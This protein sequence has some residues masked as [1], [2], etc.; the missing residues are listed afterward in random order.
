MV[1]AKT[2]FFKWYWTLLKETFGSAPSSVPTP[3]LRERVA[4]VTVAQE[5]A[6]P[7]IAAA[8]E[9][10]SR[11]SPEEV[12]PAFM[13]PSVARNL[14][15]QL[16]SVARLNTPPGRKPRTGSGIASSVKEIPVKSEAGAKRQ[17]VRRQVWIAARPV[18]QP[19]PA[20]VVALPLS[21]R[22]PARSGSATPQSQIAA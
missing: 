10:Q 4:V 21:D 2:G 11:E 1:V 19:L 7:S 18:R 3:V 16:H 17:P 14:S 5:E 6:A 22:A 20:N 8:G 15:A 13:R 12:L 9:V